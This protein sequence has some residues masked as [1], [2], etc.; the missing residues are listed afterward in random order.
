[1]SDSGVGALVKFGA[2]LSHRL[3][4]EVLSCGRAGLAPKDS[5]N[6]E[7]TGK[8]LLFDLTI[9]GGFIF[10]SAQLLD[11]GDPPESLASFADGLDGWKQICAIVRCLERDQIKSLAK[12]IE[13]CG[14][15]GPN[16]WVIS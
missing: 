16:G 12:P 1:M 6:L 2:W 15:S 11:R 5:C 3:D 10:L 13:L 8:H 7:L 9:E 4:L 14:G